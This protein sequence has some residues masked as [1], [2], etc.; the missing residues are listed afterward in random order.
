MLH[1]VMYVA[2]IV[3]RILKHS[4]H[5]NGAYEADICARPSWGR[6]LIPK[7]FICDL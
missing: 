5:V 7:Y 1:K 3:H 2:G 4:S 6:E